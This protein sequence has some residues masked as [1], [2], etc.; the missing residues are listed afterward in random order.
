MLNF[1]VGPFQIKNN[2][3][4]QHLEKATQ[5][6]ILCYYVEVI[7]ALLTLSIKHD[8]YLI[9]NRNSWFTPGFW[10]GLLY[11]NFYAPATKSQ[12]AY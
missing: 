4:I 10:W 6:R 5:T 3:L 2:L 1:Q 12:G 7:T 8:R 9:R 11:S